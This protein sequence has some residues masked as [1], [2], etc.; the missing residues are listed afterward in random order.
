MSI[1]RFEVL[2]ICFDFESRASAVLRLKFCGREAIL[3]RAQS[4]NMPD[5]DRESRNIGR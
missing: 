4:R 1:T 5:F 3:S 2:K